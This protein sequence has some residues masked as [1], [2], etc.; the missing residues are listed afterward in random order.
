M[1]ITTWVNLTAGLIIFVM[2]IWQY[3]RS[4]GRTVLYVGVAFGLFALTH[5]LTLMGLA[6][7]MATL[8]LILRILAYLVIIYAIYI[9]M[10]GKKSA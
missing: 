9:A 2:G 3:T 10:T 4:K 8:I 1:D 6:A 7:S 5:L